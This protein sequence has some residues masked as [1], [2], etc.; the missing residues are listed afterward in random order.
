MR[1]L[2]AGRRGGVCSNGPLRCIISVGSNKVANAT[3]VHVASIDRLCMGR[4]G[5]RRRHSVC[6]A[7]SF[8]SMCNGPVCSRSLDVM[9]GACGKFRSVPVLRM[10][11][12]PVRVATTSR[13]HICDRNVKP[14]AGDGCA[15]DLNSLTRKRA[16]GMAVDNSLANI[17]RTGGRVG[18]IRFFSRCKGSIDM[19]CGYKG[20]SNAL[21]VLPRR[22][23]TMSPCPYSLYRRKW[24]RGQGG[25]GRWR[26]LYGRRA[27]GRRALLRERG[28]VGGLGE[29]LPPYLLTNFSLPF[30]LF[31]CNPFS[32]FTRGENRFTFS[33]CSFL[34]PYVLLALLYKLILSTVP[35]FLLGGGTCSLCITVLF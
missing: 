9:F 6:I 31:L 16:I 12:E 32:L 5:S 2:L 26:T 3:A 18:S 8:H 13:A 14:L 21:R 17:N 22:R 28:G 4:L 25:L 20:A 29:H 23:W 24:K 27:V 30:A 19:G 7:F 1:V 33:L 11:P 35:L 10:G 34:L 15:M